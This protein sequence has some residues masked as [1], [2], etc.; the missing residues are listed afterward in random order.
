MFPDEMDWVMLGL[1]AAIVAILVAVGLAG[2]K[3]Q[4][5]WE[6]FSKAMDCKV[7]GKKQGE[8]S[9]GVGTGFSS[10]GSVTTVPVTTTSSDQ[11]AYLCSNGVTYWRNE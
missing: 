7:V 10:N 4:N 6:L 3:E 9:F 2:A 1:F 11:T 5:E 8:T